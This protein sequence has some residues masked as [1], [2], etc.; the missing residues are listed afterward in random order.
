VAFPEKYAHA[1][2]ATAS[3]RVANA[4]DGANRPARDLVIPYCTYTDPE[5]A[6]VGLTRSERPSRASFWRLTAWNLP[7]GAGVHRW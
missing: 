1:A 6:T 4:L 3:L 2:R 5:V 7:S